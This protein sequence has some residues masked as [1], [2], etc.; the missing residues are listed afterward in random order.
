[1]PTIWDARPVCDNGTLQRA[2]ALCLLL[3]PTRCC[4]HACDMLNFMDTRRLLRSRPKLVRLDGSLDLACGAHSL[5]QR[6]VFIACGLSKVFP[7]SRRFGRY[8]MTFADR[9]T[10]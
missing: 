4:R 9:M 8:N 6:S 3:N 10:C 5:R 1:M 7:R 2:P